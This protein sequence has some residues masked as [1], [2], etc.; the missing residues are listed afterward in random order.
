[1]YIC[2]GAPDDVKGAC[3]AAC[4]HHSAFEYP[5]NGVTMHT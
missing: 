4:L 1:M 2:E 3:A 5:I